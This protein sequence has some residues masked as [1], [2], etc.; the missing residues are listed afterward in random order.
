MVVAAISSMLLMF[1]AAVAGAET[2]RA[3]IDDTPVRAEATLDGA[4]IATLKEGAAVDVIDVQGDYYRVLVPGDAGKPTVGYVLTRLVDLDDVGGSSNETT[5]PQDSPTA[6]PVAQGAPIPPTLV[7]LG[8]ERVKELEKKHVP[9][10]KAAAQ[11]LTAEQKA[12]DREAAAERKAMAR[13]LAAE[14]RELAAEKKATERR[15]A[16]ENKATERRLAAE[17]EAAKRV[18]AAKAERDRLNAVVEALKAQPPSGA[19]QDR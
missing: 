10:A 11:Q 2:A 7:Q 16:A 3:R 18:E 8:L 19:R 13:E 9:G 4:V 15:L 1:V 6:S 14:Q 5:V 12:I 17:R